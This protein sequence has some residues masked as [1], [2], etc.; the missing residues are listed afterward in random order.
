MRPPDPQKLL[1][2]LIAWVLPGLDP[3]REGTFQRAEHQS[4]VHQAEC[5]RQLQQQ[6]SEEHA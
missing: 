2:E 4:V 6:D 1:V 3:R 5:G